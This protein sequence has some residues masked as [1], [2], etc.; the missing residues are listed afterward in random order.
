[1]NE[2][3]RSCAIC[4]EKKDKRELLRVVRDPS[5]NVS[6][7]EGKRINGRGAYVCKNA[8]CIEKAKKSKALDRQLNISVPQ[9]IYDKLLQKVTE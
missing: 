5:G 1:M 9:E 4:R 3:L 8:K 6:L 7:D 2:V